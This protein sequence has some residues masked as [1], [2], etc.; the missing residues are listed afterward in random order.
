MRNSRSVPTRSGNSHQEPN[1]SREQMSEERGAGCYQQH[2]KECA[3]RGTTYCLFCT[4][5]PL[6]SSPPLPVSLGSLTGGIAEEDGIGGQSRRKDGEETQNTKEGRMQQAGGRR[7][8]R[9]EWGAIFVYKETSYTPDPSPA[10]ISS[11]MSVTLR[12]RVTTER[13]VT[14]TSDPCQARLRLS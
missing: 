10:M 8:R 4:S 12:L 7:G 14:E 9:G 3:H 1:N 11:E 2:R 5:Y 6:L 13:L